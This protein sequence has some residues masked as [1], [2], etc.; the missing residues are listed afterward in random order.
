MGQP[1]DKA[2]KWTREDEFLYKYFKYDLRNPITSAAKEP[3]IWEHRV[4]NFL[5]RLPET[6]T[7][8]LGYFPESLSAYDPYLFMF[9]TD[10]EDFVID[11]FSELPAT[12]SFFKVSNK[13]FVNIHV[14]E[15]LFGIDDSN[16]SHKLSIPLLALDLEEK[17]IVKKKDYVVL[18]YY[19]SKDI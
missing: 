17:G 7:I 2:I 9:D 11:L 6:C 19:R 15:K 5:G 1:H 12:S 10:Y 16:P 3:G 18:E 13:L 4:Y 8:E 14:P